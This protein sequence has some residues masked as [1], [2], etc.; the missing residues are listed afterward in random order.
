MLRPGL[1]QEDSPCLDGADWVWGGREVRL[2]LLWEVSEGEE[3]AWQEG[4]V[5]AFGVVSRVG[6][7]GLFC[8]CMF[9]EGRT[10][11]MIV[12]MWQEKGFILVHGSKVSRPSW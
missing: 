6:S 9:W 8:G 3:Q 11:L 4:C 1:V 10:E 2:F 7:V 5:L 12:E